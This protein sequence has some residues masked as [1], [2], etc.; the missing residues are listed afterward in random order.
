MTSSRERDAVKAQAG[1][2]TQR[3]GLYEDLT[4]RE[5]L[6]FVGAALPPEAI[7]A[8]VVDEALERLG[9]A[10]AP[11]PAHGRALGRLEAAAGAG[12]LRAA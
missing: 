1:Y 10:I 2:M 5:N 12:G 8:T 4:I 11:A 7:C 6:E 3:F 9:L